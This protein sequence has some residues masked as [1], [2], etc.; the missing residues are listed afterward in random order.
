VTKLKDSWKGAGAP[1]VA[2]SAQKAVDEFDKKLDGI[3][4]RFVLPPEARAEAGAVLFY[5][6]PPLAQS[7][8]RLLNQIDGYT[9]A[10]SPPQLSQIAELRAHLAETSK[11]LKQIVDEELPRLNKTINDA[12]V[13]RI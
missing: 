7:V 4:A 6:P 10:P 9:D 1:R 3:S 8:N 12:G 2:D 5:A 13:P 11:A